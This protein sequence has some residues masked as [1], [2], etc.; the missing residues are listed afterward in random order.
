MILWRSGDSIFGTR[1][2]SYRVSYHMDS[3]ISPPYPKSWGAGVLAETFSESH[4]KSAR[5]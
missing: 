2:L 5:M 1:S 3:E 4:E